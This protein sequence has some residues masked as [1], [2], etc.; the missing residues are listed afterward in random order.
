MIPTRQVDRET[1]VA[2]VLLKSE[3][4]LSELHHYY[5]FGR[6]E[7]G[8]PEKS[9]FLLSHCAHLLFSLW[10]T[11]SESPSGLFEYSPQ[12]SALASDLDFDALRYADYKRRT[13]QT[14][15]YQEHLKNEPKWFRFWLKALGTQDGPRA[16]NSD[17]FAQNVLTYV[18]HPGFLEGKAS[19]KS[20]KALT[21]LMKTDAVARIFYRSMAVLEEMVAGIVFRFTR[22]DQSKYTTEQLASLIGLLYQA[23]R[24]IV[25]ETPAQGPYVL[26]SNKNWGVPSAL[27]RMYGG[28][29]RGSLKV[30]PKRDGGS[31]ICSYSWTSGGQTK[32]RSWTRDTSALTAPYEEELFKTW[33]YDTGEHL[34]NPE[35]PTDPQAHWLVQSAEVGRLRKTCRHLDTVRRIL[36][37]NPQ[38][39]GLIAALADVSIDNQANWQDGKLAWTYIRMLDQLL[40]KLKFA[41]REAR[42]LGGNN[43]GE[44]VIAN[45]WPPV[46]SACESAAPSEHQ[47]DVITLVQEPPSAETPA[48]LE[49]A[50]P[51]SAEEEETR[52][53]E[54]SLQSNVAEMESA[55]TESTEDDITSSAAGDISANVDV[56]CEEP[57]DA[58]R[59]ADEPEMVAAPEEVHCEG[60]DVTEPATDEQ[61]AAEPEGRSEQIDEAEHV[62]IA[63]DEDQEPIQA[64]IEVEHTED[65]TT[66]VDAE[67][68]ADEPE[69][70]ATPQETQCENHDVTEP[71]TDE[72]AAAEPEG[73]SEQIDEAEHVT[74]AVDEDQEPIQATIEVEHTEDGTTP[75]DAEQAAD[76]PEAAAT[77]QEAQC[78]NHDVTEPA[79]DE[80]AAAEPEGRSD[81]IDEAEHVTSAVDEDQ[82]PIQATVEVEH[83]EDGTTPVDAEQAA[84]T[85]Q[86][87][88]YENYDVT[89]PATDDQA[90]A[91]PEAQANTGEQIFET[92]AIAEPQA[93]RIESE[94]YVECEP[95]SRERQEY[96]Q[97]PTDERTY[98]TD[99]QAD[100]ERSDT[101]R[102]ECVASPVSDSGEQG[103]VDAYQAYF[104]RLA[105]KSPASASASTTDRG[106][107]GTKSL[108]H[109]ARPNIKP[110]QRQACRQLL[111][112]L[113]ERHQTDAE[114]NG[115]SPLPLKTLQQ[116]LGWKQ[117]EVQR[118][119]TA[120]FGRRPFTV[121]KQKCGDR[122][123]V[124]YLEECRRQH[125]DGVETLCQTVS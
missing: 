104:E 41:Y 54:R 9:Y 30:V 110:Q 82:E 22:L 89:E 77:P 25:C 59:P 116:D 65:G 93:E 94:S 39:S 38:C 24:T 16:L 60:L 26:L 32:S 118:A 75:V 44:E 73:R 97:A 23:R 4:A 90:A 81:Q 84:A 10:L 63:V 8:F 15:T 95:V 56:E 100:Q 119:M 31:I 45:V 98:E 114:S 12:L 6:H 76:E 52:V 1:H 71:A 53:G 105:R 62:T 27:F 43:P 51:T 34:Q 13:L 2:D 88:Q 70:A 87:V 109:T 85:P 28:R 123:V 91:E 125:L 121:Y 11:E 115:A 106:R 37:R 103:P 92:P 48:P 40:N 58:E 35:P 78:E 14:D 21:D 7:G 80:Q 36:A 99:A 101:E 55:P 69:A 74:I 111:D 79:T 20:R 72:Q 50:E 33:S 57:V 102:I 19:K 61:A 108:A 117:S 64:T 46:Q 5:K 112:R 49:S 107:S 68:A 113:L 83:T 86:E 122:A 66:P 18:N 29:V 67:Q 3:A 96:D 124:D 17:A 47:F 120:I 42:V